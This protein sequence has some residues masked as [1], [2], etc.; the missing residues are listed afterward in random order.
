MKQT[1]ID[2]ETTT[3]DGKRKTRTVVMLGCLSVL[4]LLALVVIVFYP[5]RVH[6]VA[7]IVF[8]MAGYLG[9]MAIGVHDGEI[10][11][12]PRRSKQRSDASA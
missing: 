5:Q 1:K 4:G 9:A 10:K 8:L 7:P 12:F 6:A 3:I 2:Y 11:I